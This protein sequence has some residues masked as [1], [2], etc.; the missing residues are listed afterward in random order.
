MLLSSFYD[1]TFKRFFVAKENVLEI[2][3][4]LTAIKFS[5][6]KCLKER[7]WKWLFLL[8]LNSEKLS[9]SW[10]AQLQVSY[11]PFRSSTL[12]NVSTVFKK[13]FDR[14]YA[15]LVF[16]MI[17]FSDKINSGSSFCSSSL[18]EGWFALWFM[19]KT[20]WTKNERNN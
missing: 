7:L 20:R 10:T 8:V 1:T 12:K 13:V 15:V 3:N 6:Q 11:Q 2:E 16:V 17:S 4:S 14:C 18:I 5:K 19:H 9:Q